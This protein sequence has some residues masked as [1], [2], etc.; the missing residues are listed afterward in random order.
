MTS[1][2]LSGLLNVNK[3]AG[4][5][6]HDVVARIRKLSGQRKVGHTGTLDPMA[7]GVLLICM[8]QATRLIEYL[9]PAPKQYRAVICFGLSTDTLDAD[10]KIVAYGDVSSLS[11]AGVQA[12]LP[13]FQGE[14]EQIPPLYSALKQQGRPL[15]Q[16]ARAGE[17]I[18]LAPRR[19]TIYNLLWIKWQPPHL[20]LDITCSAGTYIRA[21]ARDLGDAAS[22]GAHLSQLT[23]L[24]NGR[25]TLEQAVSLETLEQAGPSGWQNYLH[26]ADAAIVHLPNIVLDE[27]AAAE[28]KYGRSIT[29]S[30]AQANLCRAYAPTGEFLAILALAADQENVWQPKKVFQR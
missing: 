3:P 10:G 26:P 18:E 29:L 25:W 21:L 16:R 12:L 13:Q 20:T 6:S 22:C 14:I 9:M 27:Q 5:T 17:T 8:G 4:L 28:I 30:M 11:E 1:P 2:Q 15:Y 7:T 24:A 19:V 23:R